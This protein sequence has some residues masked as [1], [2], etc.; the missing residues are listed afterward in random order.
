M[1]VVYDGDR[2]T[3][4]LIG[5]IVDLYFFAGP[6]PDAVVQQYTEL[7]GRPAPMPYWSFGKLFM[8]K[9]FNLQHLKLIVST[10]FA[11][12]RETSF[13]TIR[14]NLQLFYNV[15]FNPAQRIKFIFV[16]YLLWP[17]SEQHPT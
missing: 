5:G 2:I 6:S 10:L 16:N 14:S 1:D 13:R 17:D 9:K 3:Y 8:N 4:K 15:I 7:I 12:D 11:H